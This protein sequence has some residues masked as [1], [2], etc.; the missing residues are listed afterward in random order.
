MPYSSF[1]THAARWWLVLYVVVELLPSRFLPPVELC[2]APSCSATV[3]LSLGLDWCLEGYCVLCVPLFQGRVVPPRDSSSSHL[4]ICRSCVTTRLK[5]VL[6]G[7]IITTYASYKLL[8]WVPFCAVR[9]ASLMM[10]EIYL[11]VGQHACRKSVCRVSQR[12]HGVRRVA[13]CAFSFVVG[14]TPLC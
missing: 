5:Q 3:L 1:V 2:G 6:W 4:A 11:F 12:Q 13:F 14:R 10:M 9:P 8:R 7:K